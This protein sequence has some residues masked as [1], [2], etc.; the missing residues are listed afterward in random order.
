MNKTVVAVA[1]LLH[2]VPRPFGVSPVGALALYAG[3]HGTRRW[4]WATPFLPLT[5][6]ALVSGFYDATVM[7]FVFAGFA[8]STFAGRWF[9]RAR[10]SRLRFA[11]AITTGAVIFFLLSNFGMWAAGY[12]PP[13]AAGLIDCYLRGLPYLAQAG[14]ADGVYCF[15]LFGLHRLME[16]RRLE[17]RAA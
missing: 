16:R 4:A 13:T 9:L 11:G 6:A 2:L 17:P 15:L 12:F 1:T 8:L 5:L 10:R 3:A 14:L 7:A